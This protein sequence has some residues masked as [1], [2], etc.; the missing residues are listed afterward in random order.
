MVEETLA[1]HNRQ[2]M[3]YAYLCGGTAPPEVHFYRRPFRH[4]DWF[5]Q[6]EEDGE[7]DSV[8]A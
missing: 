7:P 8:T 2:A 6:W 4:V 5:S 3:T 1:S